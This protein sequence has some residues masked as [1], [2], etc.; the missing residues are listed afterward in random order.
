MKK[1]ESKNVGKF[2]DMATVKATAKHPTMSAGTEYK[3]HRAHLPYLKEKG[4]ADEVK[5]KEAE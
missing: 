2:N 1:Q 4:F 3:V 5:T